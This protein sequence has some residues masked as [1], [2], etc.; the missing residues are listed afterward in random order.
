MQVQDEVIVWAGEHTMPLLEASDLGGYAP[1]TFVRNEEE[2]WARMP[3]RGNARLYLID[4][5]CCSRASPGFVAALASRPSTWPPFVTFGLDLE[6]VKASH[7]KPSSQVCEPPDQLA[8]AL[9]IC[10]AYW[11]R[12]NRGME[13][14]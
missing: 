12:V 14:E 6:Q 1:V 3:P 2:F 9:T 4:S 10:A 13:L 7:I 11:V 8:A 5:D